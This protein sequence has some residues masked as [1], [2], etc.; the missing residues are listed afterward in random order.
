MANFRFGNESGGGVEAAGR[1]VPDDIRK[2]LTIGFATVFLLAGGIGG[3][4]ATAEL[5]G[6]V[7]GSGT[8]VVDSNVKKVQHQQGGIVGE[9][10][11]REGA[12]VKEGE[13]LLRLDETITRANLGIV[14]S[15]LDELTV[16]HARLV[17]ERDDEKELDLP[18]SFKPRV[19]LA[20]VQR[21]LVAEIRLRES[22]ATSREGQ[23]SQLGERLNQLG[24]EIKGL[25]GQHRAKTKEAEFIRTE[26]GE[27][28]KLWKKNLAPLSK[29]IALNREATR[30][31]GERGQL[32]ASM[33]QSR[34]RAAETRLQILQL[35]NDLKTEVTKELR[36]VQ[37]KQAELNERR[38]AAE[39]Q[40]RRVEL[41]APQAGTVHQ[42]SVHT[43]GG[44]IN[45]GEPIML[46]VPFDEALVLDVKIGPQDIS[47]VH[48]GQAANVRLTSFNQRTTPE[49]TGHVQRVSADLSRDPQS[50]QYYF[51]VRIVF[52]EEQ[53][54]RL[55]G[56]KLQ[57]G[58]PAEVYI[59]TEQR[60]ALSYLMRPLSDQIARAFKER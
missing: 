35:D 11:V 6:A 12:V 10:L 32:I 50:H 14:M 59:Q 19:A 13:L 43:V 54:K 30:I 23:R 47:Q 29:Y 3:W 53:L 18:E 2:H 49:I 46:I 55:G 45:A 27:I 28:E 52:S 39:D 38:V 56:Q 40:L 9:I 60:T 33:A 1:S 16:R 51:T 26:L 17:A 57:P 48:V 8:V 37:A 41:R 42:L 5:A 7:I 58:L 36:E 15:Q 4:A 20:E 31:D 44:V 34:A 22:R 21:M 24:E 25:E